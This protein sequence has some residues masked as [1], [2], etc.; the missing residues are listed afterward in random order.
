MPAPKKTTA[1]KVALQKPA[2]SSIKPAVETHPNSRNWLVWGAV[3]AIA[4]LG[5]VFV[6]G[7]IQS[8]AAGLV[9]GGS[10]TTPGGAL[11]LQNDLQKLGI[12]GV[13]VATQG[14]T[15]TIAL[16][17]PTDPSSLLKD[18]VLLGKLALEIGTL[19]NDQTIVINPKGYEESYSISGKNAKTLLQQAI[20]SGGELDPEELAQYIQTNPQ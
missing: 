1:P 17:V 10:I 8:T 7:Q 13:S 15:T 5:L 16:E 2:I 19:P 20:S 4:L 9:G 12:K 6:F 18:K 11:Q 14:K 3:I